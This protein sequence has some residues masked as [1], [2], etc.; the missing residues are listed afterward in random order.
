MK[1]DMKNSSVIVL[2]GLLASGMFVSQALSQGDQKSQTV[3]PATKTASIS[4][5][6]ASTETSST[7]QEAAAKAHNWHV[8]ESTRYRRDWGVDIIGARHI[9]SGEMIEFR[10]RVLDAN[11]AKALN[12]KRSTAYMIDQATG[13]KLVVP[14]ME[15]VGLLRTTAPPQQNRVYW[16][17]FANVGNVVKRGGVVNVNI[18]SFHADGLIAQ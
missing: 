5:E 12:D 3:S 17:V 7:A 18:G 8:R 13:T 9:S 2:T 10:Y 1:R 6:P 11:K 4:A 16:M 14:Q 15:K